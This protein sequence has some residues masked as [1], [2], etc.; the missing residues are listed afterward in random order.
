MKLR[1]LAILFLPALAWGLD[2]KFGDGVSSA[3]NITP[4]T[5]VTDTV[6][7]G[8]GAYELYKMNQNVD[9]AATPTFSSGTFSNGVAASTFSATSTT[10]AFYFA[11][12]V[13]VAVTTPTKTHCLAITSAGVLYISTAT[14]AIGDWIKVG[15]Q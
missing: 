9:S 15:A 2:A 8:Q 6:N 13:D 11:G 12:A 7:T 10:E 3:D 14:I 4:K 1:Y 5:V